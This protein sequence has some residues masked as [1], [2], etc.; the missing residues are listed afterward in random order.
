MF[1]WGRPGAGMGQ[2]VRV[3][4]T[5]FSWGTSVLTLAASRPAAGRGALRGQTKA[6]LA[7]I[8][9]P[10]AQPARTF[11]RQAAVEAKPFIAL[12]PNG[13]SGRFAPHVL[14]H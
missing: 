3:D 6:L 12:V 7:R 1:G 14:N 13:V 5:T 9:R 4:S 11:C 10:I 2:N 8:W